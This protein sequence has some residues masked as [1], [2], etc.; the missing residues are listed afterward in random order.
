MAGIRAVSALYEVIETLDRTAESPI[1][2]SNSPPLLRRVVHRDDAAESPRLLMSRS[3]G[4]SEGPEHGPRPS[5]ACADIGHG[6]G[7]VEVSAAGDRIEICA[8]CSIA[9]RLAHRAGSAD[10]A[11]QFVQSVRRNEPLEI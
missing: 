3:G 11:D 8:D 2:I 7:W 5:K 6:L 10:F 4:R 9:W 1:V